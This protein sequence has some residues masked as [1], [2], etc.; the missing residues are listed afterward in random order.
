[1]PAPPPPAAA[2]GGAAAR[3]EV[4]LRPT[5]P[6]LVQAL[7]SPAVNGATVLGSLAAAAAGREGLV[8]PAMVA[9]FSTNA[10]AY[11][12]CAAWGLWRGRGRDAVVSAATAA[13]PV[14]MAWVLLRRER[15]AL[16]ILFVPFFQ[17][18]LARTLARLAAF[19][20]AASLL[21]AADG[22]EGEGGG[23]AAAAAAAVLYFHVW[24]LAG[25]GFLWLR[26]R[27]LHRARALLGPDR[28]R[29]DAAWAA[30]RARP[31]AT[32]ALEGIAAAAAALAARAAAAAPP[33]QLNRR[34]TGPRCPS[35]CPPA[36]PRSGQGGLCGGVDVARASLLQGMSS[37][38]GIGDCGAGVPGTV[39]PGRPVD[40]LDQLYAAAAAAHPLLLGRVRAWAAASGGRFPG[41]GAG[42]GL[43]S[44]E[45]AVEKIVRVY[46]KVGAG[47]MGRAGRSRGGGNRALAESAKLIPLHSEAILRKNDFSS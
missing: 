41:G 7:V 25:A 27:D 21:G 12:A 13:T 40:S 1:M 15:Y 24:L 17:Q 37:F 5:G 3:V 26:R 32:A 45:R 34:S 23:A 42:A 18:G 6:W 4:D 46:Q 33:R 47:G 10:V 14:L 9:L 11:C 43:K 20:S 2:G 29:Y 31:G 30:E 35:I 16:V 28:A 44:V 22:G 19:Q 38:Q 39:D 36:P 8:R